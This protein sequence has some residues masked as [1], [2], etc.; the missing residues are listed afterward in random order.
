MEKILSCI[1]ATGS[2]H[3]GNYL[4]AIKNWVELQTQY[5]CVYGV[6]DYHAMT[7]PY[8]AETLRKTTWNMAIDLLACGIKPENLF[9]QSLVPEHTELAWMLGCVTSYGELTRQTQFKDKS[10]QIE[11]GQKESFISS[12]LF[13]YPVLQAADILMYHPDF[14][15]V[16]KDQEQHIE[17][18]RNIANR[19][20]HQFQTEYFQ[21]P[22]AL[23]TEIPKV[24]S[25]A[26]PTKKM[27]KSLGEKHCLYVFEDEKSLR[28]KIKTAVTDSGDTPE[29]E[30]SVGVANIFGLIK[31]CGRADLHDDLLARYNEGERRY[32]DL[33]AALAESVMGLLLPM[34]AR[35]AELMA[36]PKQ[37]EAEIRAASAQIRLKA[38]KTLDE[39][40]EIVGLA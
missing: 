22:Q 17:L 10:Q 38:R 12:G 4:G 32:G 28:K 7:V 27:S 26:D 16:G 3:L 40:R 2:M 23:F 21:E 18:S 39:V 33:K 37:V 31:A 34:Q 19:F 6:V 14:V 11:E 9:I 5:D 29:G 1:Q 30:M 13:T 8:H 24:L 36:N 35:R 15:P 20:N 25:L